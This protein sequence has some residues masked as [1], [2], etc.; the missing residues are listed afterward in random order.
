MPIGSRT[1]DSNLAV[2]YQVQPRAML[3]HTFDTAASLAQGKPSY[4]ILYQ[5]FETGGTSS[6]TA[7]ASLFDRL[8]DLSG[9]FSVD[10]LWR[11]H[12]NP[13][14]GELAS[15]RLANA[16]FRTTFCRIS[17]PFAAPCRPSCARFPPSRRSPRSTLQYN[18]GMRL[19][20]VS[21]LLGSTGPTWTP[22]SISQHTV[23]T[24]SDREHP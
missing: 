5:T 21:P 3:Q 7:S 20:Q 14:P 24:T 12:F 22:S 11:N 2:S 19:Y 23:Q 4:N 1:S 13:S 18:L 8:T 6:V 9:T 17:S 10:T 16:S 15:D